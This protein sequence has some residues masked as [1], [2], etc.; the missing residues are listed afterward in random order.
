MIRWS[1]VLQS[2]FTFP[3]NSGKVQLYYENIL[4]YSHNFDKSWR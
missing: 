3:E 1:M 2:P 4:A